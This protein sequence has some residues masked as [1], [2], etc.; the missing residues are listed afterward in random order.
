M[1]PGP[2]RC[3]RAATGYHA[4]D[5]GTGYRDDEVTGQPGNCGKN[6][7]GILFPGR[8]SG[9][10]GGAGLHL[11][12]RYARLGIL[13]VYDGRQGLGVYG[14][15]VDEGRK[16]DVALV[17]HRAVRYVDARDL[18]GPGDLHQTEF[19][20]YDLRRSRADIDADTDHS[21]EG[22]HIGL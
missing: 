5:I 22:I 18:P 7:V 6:L 21:P 9:D 20:E 10:D 17:Q 3:T 12:R 15:A 1:L 2:G 19:A 8:L 11:R 16:D 14:L 13:G 4:L